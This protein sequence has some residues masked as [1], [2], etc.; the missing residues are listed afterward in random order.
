[1][2]QPMQIIKANECIESHANQREK[3]KERMK[4]REMKAGAL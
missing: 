3:R 1:M 2:G 4:S